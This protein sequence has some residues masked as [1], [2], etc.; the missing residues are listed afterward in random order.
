MA[1]RKRKVNN[2]IFNIECV[3]LGK[4]FQ[5]LEFCE[6]FIDETNGK[7]SCMIDG[8][9]PEKNVLLKQLPKGFKI[10]EHDSHIILVYEPILKTKHRLKELCVI[11][12]ICLITLIGFMSFY[13]QRYMQFV[14]F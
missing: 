8:I 5:G 2:D 12:M 1:L 3:K 7:F 6:T 11:L 10:E 14:G 13:S 4:L 9:L